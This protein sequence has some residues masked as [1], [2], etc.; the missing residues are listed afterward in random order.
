M[1]LF[2]ERS[3]SN[4]FPVVFFSGSR[5]LVW[6]SNFYSKNIITSKLVN[7]KILFSQQI[8]KLLSLNNTCTS[9][10][11]FKV[12]L[13]YN[14]VRCSNLLNLLACCSILATNYRYNTCK[15]ILLN[16][17]Q[18]MTVTK[19]TIILSYSFLILSYFEG[20]WFDNLLSKISRSRK[21]TRHWTPQYDVRLISSSKAG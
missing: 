19:A 18:E 10:K 15:F 17:F 14:L 20:V 2:L 3:F 6:H 21:V 4:H 5:S 1:Q 12:V 16:G 8:W 13:K 9:F 7:S 11:K